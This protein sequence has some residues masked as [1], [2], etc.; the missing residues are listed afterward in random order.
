[1][2][3]AEVRMAA[4]AVV[5]KLQ[6]SPKAV[7]LKEENAKAVYKMKVDEPRKLFGF[8]PLTIQKTMT[9]DAD[10]GDVLKE[11]RPWYAFFTTK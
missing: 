3:A 5:E 9:T 1:V 7:E 6:I 10:N 11:Q 8:I 2:G 4:S